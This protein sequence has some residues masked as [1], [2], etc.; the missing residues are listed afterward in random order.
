MGRAGARETHQTLADLTGSPL[1]APTRPAG[2]A[3]GGRMGRECS[4]PAVRPVPRR[5]APARPP[6]ACHRAV[7][8]RPRSRTPASAAPS[9]VPRTPPPPLRRAR[10]P[11]PAAAGGA[12]ERAAREGSAG[13]AARATPTAIRS[14]RWRP[15]SARARA[16]AWAAV[17]ESV[18]GLEIARAPGTARGCELDAPAVRRPT[19]RPRSACR[20]AR[21]PWRRRHHASQRRELGVGAGPARRRTRWRASSYSSWTPV[22]TVRPAAAASVS[23]VAR[24]SRT[25]C[26]ATIRRPR[27]RRSPSRPSR[28]GSPAGTAQPSRRGDELGVRLAGIRRS[29]RSTS[30]GAVG[31]RPI[32]GTGSRRSATR[33]PP[34]TGRAAAASHDPPSS[35]A[36]PA[37]GYG[38]VARRPPGTR[39]ASRPRRSRRWS[40]SIRLHDAS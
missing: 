28:G 8:R 38:F 16:I 39:A 15:A 23:I 35:R 32:R 26:A 25:S 1:A 10:R 17:A 13:R 12:V 6:R 11:A 18:G 21:R 34:R 3:S 24:V 4:V 40:R 19:A 27:D 20:A 33:P 2:W 7:R 5:R 9:P 30:V 36:R 29:R 31:D 22:G 37:P 14:A